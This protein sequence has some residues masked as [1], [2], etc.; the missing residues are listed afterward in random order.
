MKKAILIML[1]PLMLFASGNGDYDIIQRVINFAIFAGILYYLIAQPVKNAYNGRITGIA[2]KLSSIDEKLRAS[3]A[4]R[5]EAIRQVES[6]KVTAAEL[7][8]LVEKEIEILLSKITQDTKNEI[9]ALRR[10]Y[11]DQKAFE[12]RKITRVVVSE[13]LEELFASDALKIDK[14]EFVNLVLKRVS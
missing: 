13:I 8:D 5:D 6:A 4:Q 10:S 7:G 3:N 1:A 11:E 14:D 9:E 12:E 2:G